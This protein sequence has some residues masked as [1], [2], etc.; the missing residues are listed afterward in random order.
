MTI[1]EDLLYEAYQKLLIDETACF[2][3]YPETLRSEQLLSTPSVSIFP[4]SFNPIH[5]GHRFIYKQMKRKNK[6]NSFYEMSVTKV[7]KPPTSFVELLERLRNFREGEEV[8]LTNAPRMIQKIAVISCSNLGIYVGTD[9]IKRMATDYGMFGISGLKANFVVLDREIDGKLESWPF[10]D[11]K[12][13]PRNVH[14]SV[15]QFP[16]ELM[17][18]SSTKIRQEAVEK[19]REIQAEALKI[20]NKYIEAIKAADAEFWNSM[21]PDVHNKITR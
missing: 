18:I 7:D 1:E 2:I 13:V 6:L 17:G 4:G 15:D 12:A 14:R 3:I 5:D 10:R 16:P 20:A 9:T 11:L 8:L 19:Q 21:A